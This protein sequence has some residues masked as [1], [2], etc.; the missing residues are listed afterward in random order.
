[1]NSDYMWVLFCD[2]H[3]IN[4]INHTRYMYNGIKIF[5]YEKN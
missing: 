3:K 5:F 1:M 2:F 4:F